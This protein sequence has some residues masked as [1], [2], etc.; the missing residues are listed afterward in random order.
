MILPRMNGLGGLLGSLSPL[1]M[2]L[3]FCAASGL[4]EP[5]LCLEGACVQRSKPLEFL[6]MS[7]HAILIVR[8]RPFEPKTIYMIDR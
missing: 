1:C 7:V 4:Y 8:G 2:F 6:V 5:F 3:S